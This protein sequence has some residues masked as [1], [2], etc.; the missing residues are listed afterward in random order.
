LNRA[1][2]EF[3][4]R[5]YEILSQLDADAPSTDPGFPDVDVVEAVGILSWRL[6]S[7]VIARYYLDWSTA[8]VASAFEIPEGTVKSRLSRALRRLAHELEER[9]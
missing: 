1:R 9:R 6:R 2:G 3:R 8:E 5:R 7:I 4:K